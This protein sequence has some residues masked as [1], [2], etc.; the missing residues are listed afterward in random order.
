MILVRHAM[1]SDL[2]TAKPDMTAADASGLMRSYDVGVIP[3][4]DDD[5]TFIGLVTDRDLVV[6]VVADREDPN[7]VRLGDIATRSV[8]TVTPDMSISEARAL[9]GE[10]KV[11]RLPVMKDERIVGMISLGDIALADESKRAVGEALED[12]SESPSTTDVQPNGPDRGTP[13]RVQENRE[14]SA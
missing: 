11:R 10:H 12:V 6:R 14:A 7:Q 1:S 5:G 3:V 2:K 13:Q 4:V 9:M 8:V